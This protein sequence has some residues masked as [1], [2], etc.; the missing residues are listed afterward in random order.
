MNRADLECSTVHAGE[1]SG[2]RSATGRPRMP[3]RGIVIKGGIGRARGSGPR[4]LVAGR[5]RGI[6]RKTQ[7]AGCTI[8]PFPSTP[9]QGA[10]S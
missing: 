3:I 4:L 8:I 9:I 2:G 6:A 1:E 5:I 7:V 10:L